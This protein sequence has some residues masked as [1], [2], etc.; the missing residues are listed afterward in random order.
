MAFIRSDGIPAIIVSLYGDYAGGEV[1][2]QDSMTDYAWI[3]VDEVE[4]YDL[5][6]GIDEEIRM[7]DKFLKEGKMIE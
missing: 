6:E 5:I 7:L 1:K 2:L 4:K 3:S